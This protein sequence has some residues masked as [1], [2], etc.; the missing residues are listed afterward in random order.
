MIHID[1][2]TDQ[3]QLPP[4]S[5]KENL[6]KLSAGYYGLVFAYLKQL[7]QPQVELIPDIEVPRPGTNQSSF[8]GEVQT[9]SHLWKGKIRYGSALMH[10][11]KSAKF[12]FVDTRIPIQI[13][14]IFRVEQALADGTNLTAIFAL[15]RCF[16]RGPDGLDFPWNTR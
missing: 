11:G 7:W 15:V 13:E 1:P 2:Q 12:A 9:F 16:Q 14:H 10:R 5:R 8:Y 4:P 3:I 6:R